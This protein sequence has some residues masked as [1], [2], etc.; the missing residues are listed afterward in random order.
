MKHIIKVAE[1]AATGHQ[2]HVGYYQDPFVAIETPNGEEVDIVI[3]RLCGDVELNFHLKYREASQY[4]DIPYFKATICDAEGHELDTLR[5]VDTFDKRGKWDYSDLDVNYTL[6]PREIPAGDDI[7]PLV[8]TCHLEVMLRQF[9]WPSK[10]VMDADPRQYYLRNLEALEEILPPLKVEKTVPVAICGRSICEI[11]L[12]AYWDGYFHTPLPYKFY[13]RVEYHRNYTRIVAGNLNAGRL[14]VLNAPAVRPDAGDIRTPWKAPYRIT[15]RGVNYGE[16]NV[17]SWLVKMIEEPTSEDPIE[18]HYHGEIPAGEDFNFSFPPAYTDPFKQDWVWFNYDRVEDFLTVGAIVKSF[19]YYAKE[20]QFFF[21]SGEPLIIENP[22]SIAD[23]SISVWVSA[24]KIDHLRRVKSSHSWQKSSENTGLFAGILGFIDPTIISDLFGLIFSATGNLNEKSKEL[25]LLE[26]QDPVEF[27]PDYEQVHDYET[28]V[29]PVPNLNKLPL[30]IANLFESL[31]V[32]YAQA[33]SAN[34]TLARFMSALRER[35]TAAAA[36]QEETAEVLLANMEK[37]IVTLHEGAPLAMTA[38]F[39]E[40]DKQDRAKAE[41]QIQ[42]IKNEGLSQDVI[43]AKLEEGYTQTQIDQIEDLIK[44]STYE[45]LMSS[46]QENIDSLRL[47]ALDAHTKVLSMVKEIHR[48]AA[49]SEP[50]VLMALLNEGLINNEQYLERCAQASTEACVPITEIEYIDTLCT[51]RLA[52]A[53]IRNTA[54]LLERCRTPHMRAEFAQ[55]LGLSEELILDW[56]N[57]ADLMRIQ[58]ITP[59]YAD[60][61]EKVGVDTVVELS[62][63]NPGNLYDAIQDY[64]E[65]VSWVM[66]VSKRQVAD[67]VEIAKGMDRG[68]EY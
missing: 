65:K 37:D 4:I 56:A 53:K 28:L 63:R 40:F 18:H 62:K 57:R 46:P 6:D 45:D 2:P 67:W 10:E 68:L 15:F 60:L 55:E 32:L 33:A 35:D 13:E 29:Q 25:S 20:I 64:I 16:R 38:L 12:E 31:T 44:D 21:D 47:V 34:I 8:L 24:T 43:D 1:L 52:K 19:R 9:K 51:L 49:S 48:L 59:D 58:G 39:E 66:P 26:A 27:D 5:T 36:T 7:A 30:E 17:V 22:A 41:E 50:D 23:G 14:Q 61:L 3:D 11:G 42:K 54:Q